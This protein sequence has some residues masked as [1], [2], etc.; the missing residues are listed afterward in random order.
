M[1]IAAHAVSIARDGRTLLDNVSFVL[2]AAPAI[3]VLL[4]PNGAGKS[5]F[6]RV[7]AGLLPVDSG[8][9]TWARQQPDRPRMPRLGV[10]FQKPVLLAR[11]VSANLDFALRAAGVPP[12]ERADRI[13]A[14][15]GSAALMGLAQQQA[16]T[17]SGGEQQ[18]VALARAVACEPACLILDEPAANLDPASTAAIE[19]QLIALKSAGTPVLF[20][21]HDLA[22]AR[23]LAD[24]IVFMHQGRIIESTPAAQFFT[25]P[26]SAEA[27]RYIDG[28]LLG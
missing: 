10:V 24:N 22:Q 17:L 4:G 19:R 12:G 8:T 21:T 20:I 5:L 25:S 18:R 23:R 14:A 27:R 7:L 1:P 28:H 15:L 2:E 26:Q 16:L 6:V 11:S 13:A 3:T 9:V